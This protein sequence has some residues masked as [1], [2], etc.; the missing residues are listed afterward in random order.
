[1]QCSHMPLDLIHCYPHGTL[2]FSTKSFKNRP[3]V[4]HPHIFA[5]AFVQR[6]HMF[7]LKRAVAP[8]TFC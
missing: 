6:T 1:M 5:L 2:V 7:G 8:Y 3:F 4:Q